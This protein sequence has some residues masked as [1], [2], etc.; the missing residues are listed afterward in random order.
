MRAF[1][2]ELQGQHHALVAGLIALLLAIGLRLVRGGKSDVGRALGRPIRALVI[3]LVLAG[4]RALSVP[5]HLVEL[6]W[7]LDLC[8]IVALLAGLFG[9]GEALFFDVFLR[10]HRGVDAPRIL[11]D[12][13]SALLFAAG[14]MIVLRVGFSLDL[15]PL[16]TTS[17]IVT[18]VI[19]LALQATLA[20][21]FSGLALQLERSFVA[22]DV[23]TVGGIVGQVIE[24]NWR[25]TKIRTESEDVLVVP[26][27]LIAGD[28]VLNHR[29]PEPRTAR[30]L[31]V[32]VSYD[33]PPGRVKRALV[34][35]AHA[36]PRVLREP[37]PLARVRSFGDSAVIYELQLF[38]D[39][40]V[41]YR[42]A[43]DRVLTAIWYRL[44]RDA[45]EIPY[46][47]RTIRHI[48]DDPSVAAR[49]STTRS[50]EEI[51][52]CLARIDLLSTLN[53]SER[54]QLAHAVD[55]ELY[56]PGEIVVRQ[57]EPGDSAYL[58][59]E[60]TVRVAAAGS[61]AGAPGTV[62]RLGPGA[63]FGEMSLLTDEPRSATVV[64]E[65]ACELLVLDRTVFRAVLAS[66]AR[67]AARLS[68]I[69]AERQAALDV[70]RDVS[71]PPPAQVAE[72]S[73]ALLD[74]I[75]DLFRL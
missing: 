42:D 67:I 56:A 22:G 10:W 32:G 66:N 41:S 15:G 48:K 73:K 50:P 13:S 16:L 45:I 21:V 12:L 65:T 33:V 71:V 64:A 68:E 47:T 31:S 38:L 54:M 25:S 53:D 58:V 43:E 2:H 70:R 59:L 46:P 14:V 20:N 24:M 18:A 6:L 11:R 75:R 5:L 55:A 35:A 63:F 74:R 26:N 60:G 23:I 44:R 29:R 9:L 30:F 28:K 4:L 37:A 8:A 27:S 34:E 57:A 3:F 51:S 49:A 52:G 72:R 1:L 36:E 17:A 62:A 61:A 7:A 40:M 19:G 69:L 39:D